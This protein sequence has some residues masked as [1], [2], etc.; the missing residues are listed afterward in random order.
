[1]N[2]QVWDYES[3][4]LIGAGTNDFEEVLKMEFIYPYMSLLTIDS[5]SSLIFWSIENVNAFQF[6]KQIIKI[7][8]CSPN[9]K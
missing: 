4:K 1:M 6:L 5:S 9:E 3:F 7:N 2:K 8:L